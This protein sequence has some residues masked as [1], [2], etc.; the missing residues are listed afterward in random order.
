MLHV[1]IENNIKS[2]NILTLLFGENSFMDLQTI[3][4]EYFLNNFKI[5]NSYKS[6]SWTLGCVLYKM[7]YGKDLIDNENN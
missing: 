6:D 1:D 2:P 4:P 3:C 7:L 5:E